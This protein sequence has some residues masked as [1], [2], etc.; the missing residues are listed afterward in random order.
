MTVIEVVIAMVLVTLL[1]GGLFAAG[2]KAVQFA[3]H[4]RLASEAR[5]LAKERM[6]E[7][8]AYGMTELAKPTCT[9][10][11]SDTNFSS[12]GFDIVRQP[13]L[14]WHAADGS[15]VGSTNAV[16]VEAHVDVT[17]R[18]PLLKRT[19]TNSFSMIIEK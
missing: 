11:N 9:I 10:P 7:M 12:L 14:V 19:M 13:R 16:Y 1:C 2:E 5:S 15:V 17:Y 6:E 18:S 8:I 4:N 3:E